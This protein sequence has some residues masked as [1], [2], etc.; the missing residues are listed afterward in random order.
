MSARTGWRFPRDRSW[1]VAVLADDARTPIGSGVVVDGET[2]LT[3]SHVCEDDT[4][5][6]R[7]PMV[8]DGPVRRV[9]VLGRSTAEQDLAV[10]GLDDAGGM[11]KGVRPAA[12]RSPRP[13]EL[14]GD[15]WW[16][17][18]FPGGDPLGESA[19]GEVG[20]A[21]G[22]GWVR[23]NT[24]SP[25]RV[26]RGFSG[27][28]LWSTEYQAV[29]GVVA[30]AGGG[31]GRA[32]TLHEAGDLLQGWDRTP[33]EDPEN[34]R[35]WRPRARGVAVD[36]ERGWRFRGR[37]AALSRIVQ[38]FRQAE[39]HRQVLVVT[40]SPGVGKSAVLAR[41]VTTADPA[42]RA[43]LPAEDNAVRAD[44]HSVACAVH[45]RG[46][47]A[48][49]VAT[50]IA[51]AASAR[52]PEQVQDFPAVMTEALIAGKPFNVVIDALDEAE[53]PQQ[54]RVIIRMIAR[55]L[56][57]TLPSV[58]LVIGSRYRDDLGDL[59]GAFGTGRATID[60]DDPDY[61]ALADLE[62]YA[63]ATLQLSGNE[64]GGNPY[65]DDT[66]AEPVARRIAERS[67]RNF[68]VAGLVARG[69][70][71]YDT[72]PVDPGAL[73]FTPDVDEVFHEYLDRLAPVG[74]L[75]PDA[76]LTA[77]A[78]AEMPGFTGELWSTAVRALHQVKIGPERLT[79]FARA[80]AANFLLESGTD[81]DGRTFRLFHQAL[82][83][84]LLARRAEWKERAAD[85]RELTR[86]FLTGS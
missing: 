12:W 37:T 84:S 36:S 57:E 34:S 19:R 33:A 71:L 78:F 81:A 27:A 58:R 77:L 76:A 69:H 67:G 59:L 31:N 10:L 38:W 54:A 52:A 55:P 25:G 79:R 8:P 68:L 11:P 29:V 62:A 74:E 40:G 1:V 4:V 49:D 39:D 86:A 20:S 83:D 2:V 3:C 7:F 48:L 15:S 43:Q 22:H 26:E 63:L 6:V 16:A 13:E 85:E 35:H 18:G 82:V 64:R 5:W 17:F 51:K 21:L 72:E 45:A 47:S 42:V 41:I 56:A 73:T 75:S 60:L 23:L 50:E 44:E 32:I 14:E 66:A 70:G 24:G 53:S 65:A 9:R 30:Q 80:A 28:A 46:K 61:F